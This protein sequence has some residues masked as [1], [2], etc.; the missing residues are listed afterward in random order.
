VEFRLLG[1]LEIGHEGRPVPIRAGKHRARAE[2]I[3]SDTGYVPSWYMPVPA[4]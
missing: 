4:G 1:P 2:Q 3:R